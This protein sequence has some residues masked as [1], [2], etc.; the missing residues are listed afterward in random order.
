MQNRKRRIVL[1]TNVLIASLSRRGR[2]YSVWRGFQEGKYILCISNEILDE[3]IEIIGQLMSPDIAEN[4]ADL[5]LKSE[6]VELIHPQF[7]LGLITAD[8]DDNKF[9]DCAFAANATYIVSNDAHYDI[10]RTIDFPLLL[11]IKIQEFVERLNNGLL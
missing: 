8:P 7:R 6:N 2:Y 4:V 11:V 3:Y 1:D 9:V 5:L 10:L